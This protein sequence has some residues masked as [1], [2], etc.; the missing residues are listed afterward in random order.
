[1]NFQLEESRK[2]TLDIS[3]K[4][5]DEQVEHILSLEKQ[6]RDLKN[7]LENCM[8]QL[9]EPDSRVS[10]LEGQVKHLTVQLEEARGVKELHNMQRIEELK[11]QVTELSRQLDVKLDQSSAIAQVTTVTTESSQT[12]VESERLRS[13][14]KDL[15]KQLKESQKKRE[16]PAKVVEVSSDS[17][18]QVTMLVRELELERKKVERLQANSKQIIHLQEQ[19]RSLKH[20]LEQA[21]QTKPVTQHDEVKHENTKLHEQICTL[22]SELERTKLELKRRLKSIPPSSRRSL[23]PDLSLEVKSL[24][25]K[26]RIITEERDNMKTNLDGALEQVTRITFERDD[27]TKQLLSKTVQE[28]SL[29][30]VQKIFAEKAKLEKELNTM[31]K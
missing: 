9:R 24:Q 4:Y 28:E 11:T 23:Q 19:V 5:R 10:L 25:E 21:K 17:D 8:Q 2:A 15:Q 30:R 12:R 13:Q 27:I 31:R 20:E 1:M 22:T 3:Q 18:D 6:V 29:P 16:S 14:V 7:Q 26:L